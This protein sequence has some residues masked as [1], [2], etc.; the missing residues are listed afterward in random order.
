M[1]RRMLE[2]PDS[3][4]VQVLLAWHAEAKA[5]AVREPDAMTL[6][7][8]SPEGRPSARIVLF[9]GVDAGGALCWVT[10]YHSKKAREL[11]ANPFAELV[12]FWP[13]LQ[14][15]VRVAG[16]VEAASAAA[17]DAYF[18]SRPRE[19]QLGAWASDQSEVIASRAE[20]ER[21]LAEVT[22]RFDGGPVER[23]P[24]WGIF[25]LIP[26]RLELWI[27]GAHRLHDRFVYTRHASGGWT[28]VRI[29]P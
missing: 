27:A 2:P 1:L 13:E 29:C 21:R 18:R 4:P 23:P 7:T 19:S 9:K 11:A 25:R 5:A 26:E 15:Q 20:L 22:A 6:A 28:S 10:N 16:R 17:S 14:R 3:D 12:F 8:A 24:H